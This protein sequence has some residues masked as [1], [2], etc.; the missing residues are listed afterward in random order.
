MDVEYRHLLV[1]CR[2]CGLG[3]NLGIPP[4]NCPQC[5]AFAWRLRKP[6]DAAS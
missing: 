5:H 6:G 3:W 2:E 4:R 1:R